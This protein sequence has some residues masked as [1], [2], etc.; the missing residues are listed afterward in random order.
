MIMETEKS[1]PRRTHDIV[2][3]QVHAWKTRSPLQDSKV[4]REGSHSI[5]AFMDLMRPTH[6]GEAICF[7]RPTSSVLI[8]SRNPLTDTSRNNKSG[9]PM[10]QLSSYRI[11][12][13][14]PSKCGP[15]LWIFIQ[16]L[17]PLSG[18]LFFPLF[19]IWIITLSTYDSGYSSRKSSLTHPSCTESL[20]SKHH[21]S[22][23]A[24]PWVGYKF[25]VAHSQSSKVC[26]FLMQYLAHS[27]PKKGQCHLLLFLQLPSWWSCSY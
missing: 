8:P 23:C 4:E 13:I 12:T 16:G 17:F 9:Y 1:R 21:G 26:W 6:T 10:A 7:T 18:P 5:Q 2:S 15:Y 11:L 22:L 20:S 27:C 24:S 19:F 3:V 25:L 14:T